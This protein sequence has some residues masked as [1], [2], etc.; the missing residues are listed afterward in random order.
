MGDYRIIALDDQYRYALVGS[1]DRKYL[2]VLSRTKKLDEGVYKRL[3]A[4]AAEQGFNV[5]EMVRTP[6][7]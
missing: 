6:Q 3:L 2:W 7:T 4:T 1:S 5:G